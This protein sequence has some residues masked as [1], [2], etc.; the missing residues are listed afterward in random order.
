MKNVD[1][2]YEKHYIA[3]KNYYEGD[4]LNK[5]KKKKFDYRSLNC[6]IKQIKS[7]NQMKKQKKI[8]TRLQI[9]KKMLIKKDL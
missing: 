2:L 8:L 1:E 9:K 4:E 6:L 5:D 3:Y 7:Q